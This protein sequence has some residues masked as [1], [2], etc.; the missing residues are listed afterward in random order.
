MQSNFKTYFCPDAYACM[1]VKECGPV[2]TE[3]PGHRV[4]RCPKANCRGAHSEEEM[5]EK[6]FIRKF[7]KLDF[8][9]FKLGPYYEAI[10]N[11]LNEAKGKVSDTKLAASLG[12]LNKLNFVEMLQLWVKVFMWTSAE[13]K[14]GSKRVPRMSIDNPAKG[15]IEDHMWALE[16][17]TK[18]CPKN[19]EVISKITCNEKQTIRDTCL[20]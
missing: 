6:D 4:R 20:G 7:H 10:Y 16:R 9:D 12:K 13:K 2:F 1:I 8:T 19:Q 17:E 18:M 3:T 11:V 15:I 5:R 14:K